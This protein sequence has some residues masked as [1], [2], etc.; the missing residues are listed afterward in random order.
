MVLER[1]SG[2]NNISGTRNLLPDRLESGNSIT[3][4]ID[5]E[6]PGVWPITYIFVK[7]YL[8]HRHANVS[9]FEASFVPD[10]YRKGSIEYTVPR[11]KRGIYR[12]GQT[13]CSTGDIFNLFQH[14][15]ELDYSSTL[16]VYPR[17]VPIKQWIYVQ[18]LLALSHRSSTSPHQ[19]ETIYIDGIREYVPGDRM[20]H[21]HWNASAKTGVLKSKEFERESHPKV[22]I[23][24][25][26]NPSS[27]TGEEQ[28]E[29]AVNV[30]ASI[31]P[32]IQKQQMSLGILSSGK[33]YPFL[34][35]KQGARFVPHIDNFLLHVQMEG[36][37]N[38]EDLIFD[39]RLPLTSGTVVVII[40]PNK[41]EDLL[42]N[43]KQLKEMK[44]YPCHLDIIHSSEKAKS[45]IWRKRLG[46]QQVPGYSICCLDD[47]PVMLRGDISW[48]L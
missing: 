17:T 5:F 8:Y 39:K 23:L 15:S 26:R 4:K 18:S 11:L 32:F 48:G 24:L 14:K 22:I 20:S 9:L 29:L 34:E 3:I 41:T 10:F 31:V 33:E 7:E 37:E 12:F 1:W 47:L 19:R 46:T 13:E 30:V 45:E 44:M 16:R 38:L 42:L 27:Y 36:T 28:F 40:T 25:D 21:I 35:M 6:I 43:L 2:I